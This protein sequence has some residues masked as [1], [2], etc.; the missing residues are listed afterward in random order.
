MRK[1]IGNHF[2]VGRNWGRDGYYGE[3]RYVGEYDQNTL[4]EVLKINTNLKRKRNPVLKKEATTT[5]KQTPNIL[6]YV[7]GC[8]CPNVCLCT[9][10]ILY[11]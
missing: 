8:F 1:E 10:C 4:Y 6:F 9:V 11:P 2:R 5:E 7:C 3:S